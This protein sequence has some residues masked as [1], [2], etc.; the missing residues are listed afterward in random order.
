ME[1][2]I[3]VNEQDE[4]IG[5]MEK[6]EAHEKALL[7]RAFSVFIFNKDGLMLLQ[8]R[9]LTKYHSPGLWTN[10]CCSHPRPGEDVKN[11]ALRRLNE[12]LGFS[13]NVEKAFDFTYRAVFDNGLTEHEFDH[14]FVGVYDGAIQPA[15]EEVSAVIYKSMNAIADDI[16]SVPQDYTEWFKIAFPLLKAWMEKNRIVHAGS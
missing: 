14:V 12:E 4:A 3:L 8:Q 2:I 6:M 11:A 15:P 7:H 10:A 1:Q 13:V 5:V 16:V 9:A